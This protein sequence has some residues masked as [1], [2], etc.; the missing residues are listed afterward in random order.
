MNDLWTY[1]A[2]ERRWQE[3]ATTGQRPSHRSNCTINYDPLSNQVVVFGGGGP[4]KQ[5]FNAVSVL[6]WETKVW[7]EIVPK[8]NEPAPWERTYH[9]AELRYP[10]LVVF[11][12]EGLADLDDLW[13]FDFRSERWGEVKM[14]KEAVRPCARRFHS[15]CLIGNEFYVI[16]GCH[17]KYRCLSDMYSLDLSPLLASGDLTTLKWV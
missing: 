14:E 6:N 1:H 2:T 4:N 12:G 16:A 17:S 15:S 5:R 13:V 10:Y 3:V 7:R 8:E 9:V 11:G